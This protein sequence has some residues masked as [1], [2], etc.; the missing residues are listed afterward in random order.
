MRARDLGLGPSLVT[1]DRNAGQV[2]HSL[3]LF[4]DLPQEGGNSYFKGL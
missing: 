1:D 4:P 3:S 2:T